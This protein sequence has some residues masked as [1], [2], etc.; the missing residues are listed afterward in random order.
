MSD[1]AA[2]MGAPRPLRPLGEYDPPGMAAPDSLRLKV[3]RFLALFSKS[4]ERAFIGDDQL[5]KATIDVLDNIVAPPACGPVIADLQDDVAAWL[6]DPAAP[7]IRVIVMPP[8]EENG[9][10]DICSRGSDCEV[11]RPPPSPEL[12]SP[13]ETPLPSL[14]GDGLLVIPRLE[15]WFLRNR[16]GLIILR[17]LL[18]ALH[19]S[20]R[21]CLIGCNSWA[22]SFLVKAVEV[23]MVLPDP[24]T[25]QPFDAARLK[26]WFADLSGAE[27][28]SALRFKYSA[29]GTDVFC[30]DEDPDNPGAD[31]HGGKDYF[32]QLA[33]HSLGIPWIAWHM[34]RRSLWSERDLIM[35]E[36]PGM[37]NAEPA[38]ETLWVGAL[39]ELILPGEHPQTALLVMHA[40]LI[41]GSMTVD[42]IRATV[43][44]VGESNLVPSLLASG[45]LERNAD[46]ISIRAAAYPAIRT[47]LANAGFPLDRL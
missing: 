12:V 8:C 18:A 47:S 31:D 22:W 38:M 14:E 19:A 36:T 35:G 1:A 43:P 13:V 34:W 26:H 5:R 3:A 29:T 16:T 37:N 21:R 44:I 39:D 20:D 41:H 45:F 24:V 7:H 32:R 46:R 23:D 27:G 4:R 2:I 15:D 9:I 28:T 33:A 42:D 40:L 10:I 25:F 17:R 30:A 6:V 11:L